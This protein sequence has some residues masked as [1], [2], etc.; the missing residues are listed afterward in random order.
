MTKEQSVVARVAKLEVEAGQ[1]RAAHH[2]ANEKIKD[3]EA[4][5]EGQ[6]TQYEGKLVQMGMEVSQVKV[7]LANRNG[8]IPELD[9]K[10]ALQEEELVAQ[11]EKLSML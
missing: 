7:Y 1:L 2:E 8:Q 9:D 4:S 6:R 3:L 5:L 10:V 11:T